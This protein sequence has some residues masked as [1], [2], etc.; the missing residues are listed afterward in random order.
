[1]L[2]AQ[3]PFQSKAGIY[4]DSVRHFVNV[5]PG[6]LEPGRRFRPPSS[7]AFLPDCAAPT[8]ATTPVLGEADM[9]M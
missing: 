3:G 7:A 2:L 5:H 8:L 1:M 9:R 6:L 4:H